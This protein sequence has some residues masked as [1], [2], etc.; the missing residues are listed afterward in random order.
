MAFYRHSD[1]VIEAARVLKQE[2]LDD[3]PFG[4]EDCAQ[5][6]FYK[7]YAQVGTIAAQSTEAEERRA[8]GNP[9]MTG[10]GAL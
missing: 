10:M 5:D 1:E 3:S 4:N 6:W 9:E 8:G 7:N 2:L